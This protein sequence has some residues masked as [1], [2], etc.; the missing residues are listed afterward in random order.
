MIILGWEGGLTQLKPAPRYLYPARRQ[1][2][3]ETG[4][5]LAFLHR[6]NPH[7]KRVLYRY[8]RHATLPKDSLFTAV[9]MAL[10]VTPQNSSFMYGNRASLKNSAFITVLAPTPNE[11]AI[12]RHLECAASRQL[13]NSAFITVLIGPGTRYNLVPHL[14]TA[15]SAISKDLKLMHVPPRRSCP[16]FLSFYQCFVFEL[17]TNGGALCPA[18]SSIDIIMVCPSTT[19]PAS[20]PRLGPQQTTTKA[21]LSP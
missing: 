1:C 12:Y 21:R 16:I 5:L 19:G 14:S 9:P 3:Q 13:K 7:L 18:P 15:L 11:P 17:V 20:W 4:P 2:R 6:A 8:P 10:P